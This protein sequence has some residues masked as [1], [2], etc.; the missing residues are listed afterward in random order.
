MR[1]EKLGVF[2]D[3]LLVLM[4]PDKT[5]C[6]LA[7]WA[8]VTRWEMRTRPFVRTLEFLW[9]EGHT[10]HL[11]AEEAEE[12]VGLKLELLPCPAFEVLVSGKDVIS[13]QTIFSIPF[14][15]LAWHKEF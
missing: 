14:G 1:Q 3:S 15:E 2:S 5:V 13:K 8:N 9:Q 10:A 7:Q 12:E 4:C 6:L 11:S